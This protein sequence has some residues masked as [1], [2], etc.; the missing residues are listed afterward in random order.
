VSDHKLVAVRHL[1]FG[2]F[3]TR[4]QDL[5][6][7]VGGVFF[8][9]FEPLF[10]WFLVSLTILELPRVFFELPETKSIISDFCGIYKTLVHLFESVLPY[11]RVLFPLSMGFYEFT[12]APD[13]HNVFYI[14]VLL[15]SLL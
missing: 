10:Y 6:F 4:S 14:F 11:F 13:H 1:A 3:K 2:F 9:G 12:T 15:S 5:K 8:G 7:S